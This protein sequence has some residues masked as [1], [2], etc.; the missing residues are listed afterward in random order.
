S[1]Q[2]SRSLFEN[3]NISFLELL[4]ADRSYYSAQ[5]AL[6]DS[7]IALATQY[8]A[9]MKALGGGWDGVVD[10]SRPEVVDGVSHSLTKVGQ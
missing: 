8:I 3:G 6:K 1:L 10:V 9:L 5:M 4:N 7:R 2:L